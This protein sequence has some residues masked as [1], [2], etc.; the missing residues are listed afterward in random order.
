MKGFCRRGVFV[1]ELQA[2]RNSARRFAHGASGVARGVIEETTLQEYQIAYRSY[3]NHLH[4]NRRDGH[5]LAGKTDQSE[6]SSS[7]QNYGQTEMEGA[8]QNRPTPKKGGWGGLTE[9]GF[10]VAPREIP[11]RK[12]RLIPPLSPTVGGPYKPKPSNEPRMHYRKCGCKRASTN[13]RPEPFGEFPGSEVLAIPHLVN[14]ENRPGYDRNV[15]GIKFRVCRND[16]DTDA[17]SS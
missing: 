12:E 3:L 11:G 15:Y 2:C 14:Y 7:S 6:P 9:S 8:S 4:R 10:S 17:T 13:P 1:E 5:I 16:S